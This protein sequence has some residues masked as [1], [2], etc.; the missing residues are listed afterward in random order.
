MGKLERVSGLGLGMT[1]RLRPAPR[2]NPAPSL[3]LLL[4]PPPL[5]VAKEGWVLDLD[6]AREAVEGTTVDDPEEPECERFEL[7]VRSNGSFDVFTLILEVAVVVPRS[8]NPIPKPIF[9]KLSSPLCFNLAGVRAPSAEELRGTSSSSIVD[10]PV[11]EAVGLNL[12][13][14]SRGEGG[15]MVE[16]MAGEAGEA[17]T[18][19]KLGVELDVLAL[20]SDACPV[21]GVR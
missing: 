5:K 1:P 20:A 19:G 14:D 15:I 2:S 16:D 6:I 7:A 12:P 18:V 8:D 4:F 17:G 3:A 11:V 13:L 9:P 10:K 21:A